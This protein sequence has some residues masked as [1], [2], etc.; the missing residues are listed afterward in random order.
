MRVSKH[1]GLA[2]ALL[3]MFCVS[4]WADTISLTLT[5]D[6]Y[7]HGLRPTS[8]YGL[9]DDFFVTSYG[10]KQG[11][12]RFDAASIAG[13]EINSAT[14]N[15]YLNDIERAGTI[16]IHAVTSS[17]NESTVTWDNQPPAEI[18]ATAVVSLAPADEEAV[19]SIDVT[20]VVERWADGS[21]ADGGFLIVTPDSIKAYFDAQEKTGGT[22]ATLE[23]DT[24][25]PAYSGE[26]IVLDLSEP[27]RKLPR[28]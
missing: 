10:P 18:S 23:V 22:P 19:V 27:D 15:L 17:W 6:A 28:Q 7:I 5:D 16:S 4:G 2:A 9:Q 13:L 25:S 24:G 14:L 20:E 1:T 21:L 3:L 11:L 8:V 26:A 12:V